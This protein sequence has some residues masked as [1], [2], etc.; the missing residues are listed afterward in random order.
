MKFVLRATSSRAF[1][2]RDR[3][4][5]AYCFRPI[6]VGNV[7]QAPPTA[8][9]MVGAMPA[10]ALPPRVDSVIFVCHGNIMRSAAAAGFLR[11]ELRCGGNHATSASPRRGRTRTTAARRMRALRK[12]RDSSASRCCDHA[13]ARLTKRHGRRQR[14]HSPPWTEPIS[15]TLTTTFPEAR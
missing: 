1:A 14:C 2:A 4:G 6:G 5:L 10:V 8:G 7:R 3:E 15:S 11:D 12:P 9:R 13:A